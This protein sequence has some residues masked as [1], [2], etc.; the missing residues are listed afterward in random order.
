MR[1]QMPL[2]I[3]GT[4]VVDDTLELLLL[5]TAVVNR[6]LPH[7][8]LA[9]IRSLVEDIDRLDFAAERNSSG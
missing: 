7:R 5:R 4:A 2:S 8:L 9:A 1:E 3:S 6:S